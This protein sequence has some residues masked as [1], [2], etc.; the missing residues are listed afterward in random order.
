MNDTFSDDEESKSAE[1]AKSS[2]QGTKKQSSPLASEPVYKQFHN[3]PIYSGT[4][5]V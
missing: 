5:V 1:K 3:P 4:P 2:Y